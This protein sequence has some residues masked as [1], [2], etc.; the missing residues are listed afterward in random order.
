[1]LFVQEKVCRGKLSFLHMLFLENEA[2]IDKNNYGMMLFM[3][4]QVNLP[5]ISSIL[6]NLRLIGRHFL[7]RSRLLFSKSLFSRHPIVDQYDQLKLN[8]KLKQQDYSL[9]LS[10]GTQCHNFVNIWT[11]S[12]NFYH[13]NCL[14]K[15]CVTST[16]QD[17]S[18]F[19]GCNWNVRLKF[20]IKLH[21]YTKRCLI[22]YSLGVLI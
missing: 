15:I 17:F 12:M 22:S 1:M 13:K 19:L 7:G 9:R 3:S 14:V 21:V 11:I 10:T 4:K 8:L 20:H 18:S 16:Y 6:Q 5:N 2:Q